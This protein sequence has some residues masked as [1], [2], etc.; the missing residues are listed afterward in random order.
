[1]L[2]VGFSED[3][4]P[5]MQEL[6]GDA[7]P[8]LRVTGR[9]LRGPPELALLASVMRMPLASGDLTPAE[10]AAEA[11]GRVVLVSGEAAGAAA[12]LKDAVTER[13]LQPA[14]WGALRP[15]HRGVPLAEV[16]ESLR[17]AHEKHWNLT[18]PVV[19]RETD[20]E[21]STVRVAMNLT[22][23][24]GAVDD[25]RGGER[26]D[27][28]SIVVLDGLVGEAE[29]SALLDAITAPGWDHSSGAPPEKGK[30]K[31]GK[32]G[33]KWERET[34]D[35]TA[36]G[37]PASWGLTE[38][39]LAMLQGPD[40][41]PAVLEVQSRLAKLYPEFTV[42]HLNGASL[43][44]DGEVAGA[45]VAPLVANAA[46]AGDSFGWHRDAQPAELSP[47]AP[48]AERNGLYYNREPGKPLLVSL[49]VYLND[50]WPSDY[51]AETLF[52]DP[53]TGT[54]VIVRPQPGRC[55][56]M[57]ADLLHRLSPPSRSAGKPR[58]SLVWKLA[59]VPKP[60]LRA[61]ST[62]TPAPPP[63]S[64]A[65]PEWG[66]PLPFGSAAGY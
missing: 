49:I 17:A 5:V 45:C 6:A 33:R 8:V 1:M 47:A 16:A 43:E 27:S 26:F 39:G 18:Q 35:T 55:V 54:G 24:G 31:G 13:G 7:V 11:P 22:I 21:P 66:R 57:D 12:A 28:G 20:W 50:A 3:E 64:I 19:A 4:L 10:A 30:V 59:L 48:W 60:A 63:C 34:R 36:E 62:D 14:V 25:T 2:L 44:A 65:R 51:D 32:D 9:S 38:E 37:A 41:P 56:L 46:V 42:C 53:A 29:R 58:Y 52:L 40:A 15:V 61:R 23:D